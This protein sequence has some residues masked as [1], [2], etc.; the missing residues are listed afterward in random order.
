M[1]KTQLYKDIKANLEKVCNVKHVRLFNNQFQHENVE[2][3]FLYPCVFIE[4]KPS[5]Y[6]DKLDKVQDYDMIIT[7]H[8]G[9]ES[10][11]T[12]D[13]EVLEFI[14][15][16][17][18]AIHGMNS[19]TFGRLLRREERQDFDHGNVQVYQMDFITLGQDNAA[20][21]VRKSRIIGTTVTT[22]FVQPNEI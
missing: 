7:L 15:N 14:E 11:N 1:S 22:E 16:V 4:F 21:P 18:V 17:Y 8:I 12:D 2:E 6:R 10:Y 9:F 19:G 20:Q 13:I 5:T 3:S